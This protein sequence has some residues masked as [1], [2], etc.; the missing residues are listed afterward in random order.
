MYIK[1]WHAMKCV[2]NLVFTA[3]TSTTRLAFAATN[4]LFQTG[5]TYYYSSSLSSCYFSDEKIRDSIKS[6][7]STH[8]Y[9]AQV[10]KGCTSPTVCWLF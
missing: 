3:A 2:L 5:I 7:L 4:S 9:M 1:N 10:L 6:L 8:T